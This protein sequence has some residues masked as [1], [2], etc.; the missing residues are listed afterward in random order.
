MARFVNRGVVQS[1]QRKDTPS[2]TFDVMELPA[3]NAHA[4]PMP[5]PARTWLE[6][7]LLYLHLFRIIVVSTCLVLLA[8]AWLTHIQWLVNA[9]ACIAIG[10]FIESTYYILVLRWATKSG[11]LSPAAASWSRVP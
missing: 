5:Q 6:W 11:R 10:E 9:S 2:I 4:V 7:A 1:S 3:P 8:V